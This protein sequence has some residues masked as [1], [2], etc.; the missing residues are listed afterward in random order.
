MLPEEGGGFLCAIQSALQELEVAVEM[1]MMLSRPSQGC[2]AP[3]YH[4]LHPS[5]VPSAV[6]ITACLVFEHL[7]QPYYPITQSTG[8]SQSIPQF[9]ALSHRNKRSPHPTELEAAEKSQRVRLDISHHS[10]DSWRASVSAPKAMSAPCPG[11]APAC[12]GTKT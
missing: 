10:S 5:E 2:L 11:P 3:H 12:A 4:Q 6:S 1:K 9:P 8:P 7:L